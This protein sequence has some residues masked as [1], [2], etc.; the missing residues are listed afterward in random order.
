[1]NVLNTAKELPA[2]LSLSL[3]L[4]KTLNR[5]TQ[6]RV[7]HQ[8]KLM[9]LWSLHPPWFTFSFWD[10][11][12]HSFCNEVSVIH[13][14]FSAGLYSMIAH[15]PSVYVCHVTDPDT[16]SCCSLSQ[17]LTPSLAHC[18]SNLHWKFNPWIPFWQGPQARS[19]KLQIPRGDLRHQLSEPLALWQLLPPCFFLV[20]LFSIAMFLCFW[21]FTGSLP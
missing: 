20:T 10:Q 16:Q 5:K 15:V 2:Y 18:H 17:L 8:V 6:L 3:C 12:S 4:S 13:L 7:V 1:M 19:T 11:I 21:E 9:I 14:C